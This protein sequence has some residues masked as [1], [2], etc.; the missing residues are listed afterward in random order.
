MFQILVKSLESKMSYYDLFLWSKYDVENIADPKY[1]FIHIIL[2]YI[3]HKLSSR[4]NLKYYLLKW[5]LGLKVFPLI[6]LII[7]LFE[8]RKRK[9]YPKTVKK[10][11]E[12]KIL[13]VV[14]ARPN[15]IKLVAVYKFF[16]DLFEH[17][18]VDTGQHYDYEMNKI[19]LIN[20]RF[21][22]LIIFLML[23]VVL[24]VI[25]LVRLL[26]ELRRHY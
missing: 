6:T 5:M 23:A 26:N 12:L 7:Y 8:A 24:M 17:I 20:L 2:L 4:E 16:S 22:S 13:S 10:A 15:Y 18:I 21:L 25:K 1:H 11:L 19:F 14:G 3:L 9:N